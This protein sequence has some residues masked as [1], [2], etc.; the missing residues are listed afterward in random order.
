MKL[1]VLILNKEEYLETILEGYI[2][3]GITG[4]TVIDSIGM[5]HILSSEIP[6]FAGLRFMFASSRPYN[7]TV[8]SV[9]NE[10]KINPLKNVVKKILGP[11]DERGK[12]ILFFI[13]LC[14]VEG[15]KM[16]PS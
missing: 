10:D 6:I 5:G 16:E 3:I 14:G 12:G 8:L 11:L 7:K 15:L 13:D 9:I 1:S 2:E 4:A